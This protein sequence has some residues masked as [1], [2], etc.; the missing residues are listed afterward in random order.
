M[1]EV[2]DKILIPFATAGGF[3]YINYFIL[4]KEGVLNRENSKEDRFFFL[5]IFSILNL[6]TFDLVG[7]LMSYILCTEKFNEIIFFTIEM[8]VTTLISIFLIIPIFR[9]GTKKIYEW[10]NHQ[11]SKS[12]LSRINSIPVRDSMFDNDRYQEAYVINLTENKII[13]SGFVV[14]AENASKNLEFIL[15][16][17]SEE[18]NRDVPKDYDEL[19]SYCNNDEVVSKEYINVHEKIRII[20]I[21]HDVKKNSK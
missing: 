13:S 9:V 17:F 6:L 20:I 12:G 1:K 18:W 11:R 7:K 4:H 5:L 16:P 8:I 15:E 19:I 3:G 21:Y 10:L 14:S 2:L